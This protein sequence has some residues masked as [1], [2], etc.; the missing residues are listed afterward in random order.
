[1][2]T[3]MSILCAKVLPYLHNF[4]FVVRARTFTRNSID[5]SLM[6]RRMKEFKVEKKTKPRC[7]LYLNKASQFNQKHQIIKALIA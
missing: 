3:E 5:F 6:Y 2:I 7:N 4:I 1:M